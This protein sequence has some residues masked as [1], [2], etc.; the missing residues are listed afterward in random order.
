MP[1]S[2]CSISSNVITRS[3]IGPHTI[4][5]STDALDQL[6]QHY[7]CKYR[8]IVKTT[9]IA[10]NGFGRIG[11]VTARILLGRDDLELVAVNDLTDNRTLAH[12][13]STTLF[14]AYSR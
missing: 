12:L 10:I 5:P 13:F 6:G 7:V 8:P 1:R 3:I 2:I 4:S 9:R 14:T 11:R